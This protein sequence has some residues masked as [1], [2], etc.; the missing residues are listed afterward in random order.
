MSADTALIALSGVFI[1]ILRL[2]YDAEATWTDVRWIAAF[3]LWID[4]E[5]CKGLIL[6]SADSIYWDCTSLAC[7]AI[8]VSL[9]SL[10]L[11]LFFS[12]L[13]REEN[14]SKI[15]EPI[16]TGLLKPLLFP[17]RT[18][19]TR[20]FPKKHSFSY[21]YLLV[22]IPIGWRGAIGSFLSADQTNNQVCARQR[23]KTWLSVNAE[24]YLQ[25]GSDVDGLKGKLQSFLTSQKEDLGHYSSVYLVTAPRF[26]GYSFNPASFWYLY[27]EHKYLKAMIVEVNNTFDERRLYFLK[28]NGPEL[29]TEAPVIGQPS[30]VENT[31]SG[32]DDA[33]PQLHEAFKEPLRQFSESWSKDFHVSPFNSRKGSYSLSAKDIYRQR[34]VDSVITLASSKGHPKLVARIFSTGSCLDPSQMSYWNICRFVAAWWWVGF[35][36]FPR[37]LKEAAKL[38]FHKKLHVWYRPEVLR[39]SLGRQATND[40]RVIENVFRAFLQKTVEQSDTC[41]PLSY[42]SPMRGIPETFHPQGLSDSSFVN[43]LDDP[44]DFRVTS[45]L[46]YAQLVRYVHLSEFFTTSFLAS[47]PGNQTFYVSDPQNLLKIIETQASQMLAAGKCNRCSILEKESCLDFIRWRFLRW[48][49]NKCWKSSSTHPFPQAREWSAHDIRAFSFSALDQFS[50]R[51]SDRRTESRYRKSVT[52][53]LASDLIAFGQ[54]ALIDTFYLAIRIIFLWAFVQSAAR[55]SYLLHHSTPV[56]TRIVGSLTDYLPASR[57]VL[58]LL[59][60]HAWWALGH[61]L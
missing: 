33:V 46:F 61:I 21:S 8:I 19:H 2:Y 53:M 30:T 55:T 5:S 47:T 17:S 57:T 40:E 59:G 3:G 15:T 58:G 22:G 4:R 41:P 45:P 13:S 31:L 12:K 16:E 48:L 49:R 7:A 52:K 23:Q 28:D 10:A 37:I 56:E 39:T 50:M 51:N 35:V 26:L 60:M 42:T 34:K 6:R 1:W 36:T 24:D 25:R 14:P 29:N 44:V 27:D 38:F 32:A 43:L 54:P 20:F 9:S 18:T 11:W